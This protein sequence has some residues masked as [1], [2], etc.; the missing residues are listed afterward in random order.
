M[1]VWHAWVISVDHSAARFVAVDR[2]GDQDLPLANSNAVCLG[3][4][5]VDQVISCAPPRSAWD[6]D[7]ILKPCGLFYAWHAMCGSDRWTAASTPLSCLN[8]YIKSSCSPVRPLMP[9]L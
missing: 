8:I 9:V 4:F 6:R 2:E 5:L 7:Y 1:T 3:T